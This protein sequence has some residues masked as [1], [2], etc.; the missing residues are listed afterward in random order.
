M[1]IVA[2]VEEEAV[3]IGRAAGAGGLR[4]AIARR[5]A[6]PERYR[7]PAE[8]TLSKDPDGWH[9]VVMWAQLPSAQSA[10]DHKAALVEAHEARHGYKP[11]FK[12]S[13]GNKVSVTVKGE[14]GP[15]NWSGL[16]AMHKSNLPNIPAA[17]GV[18]LIAAVCEAI[19]IM[20]LGGEERWVNIRRDA[21][22]VASVSPAQPKA[23]SSIEDWKDEIRQLLR[24][25]AEEFR[26]KLLREREGKRPTH[27][28]DGIPIIYGHESDHDWL[29]QVRRE[30]A[31]L[32]R[33]A[34]WQLVYIGE[35]VNLHN[36]LSGRIDHAVKHTE[37]KPF[38]GKCLL[39]WA[40]KAVIECGWQLEVCWAETD[41]REAREAALLRAHHAA[42]GRLP[43]FVRSDNREFVR[44]NKQFPKQDGAIDGLTW[45][46]WHPM[47]KATVSDIPTEPGVYCIRALPPS[48]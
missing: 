48:P 12:G 28:E 9:G 7:S 34:A 38:E 43:G 19:P 27:T 39:A 42:Y 2:S 8:K 23:P 21:N 26:K 40:E 16:L 45:S 1:T 24:P 20:T 17:P 15:L 18:F 46:A 33:E 22:R 4:A 3:H 31:R 6:D 36:R 37:G 25:V 30:R 10:A 29:R 5:I 35:G 47:E 11:S 32:A 13:P 14:V 41:T 44:G